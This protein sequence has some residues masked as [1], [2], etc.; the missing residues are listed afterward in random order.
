M[1]HPSLGIA[2]GVGVGGRAGGVGA[3]LAAP[4]QQLTDW[5]MVSLL[6]AGGGGQISVGPGS[7]AQCLAHT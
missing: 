4:G 3:H 1:L 2:R 6:V 5:L 7:R